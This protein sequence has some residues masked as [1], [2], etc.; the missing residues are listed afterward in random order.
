[1]TP[2]QIVGLGVRLFAIWLGLTAISDFVHALPVVFNP[3]PGYGEHSTAAALLVTG[4]VA[5]LFSTTAAL[6]WLFP[7]TVAHALVP[8][9][10][11]DN[12]LHASTLEVARVGCC[13]LGLWLLLETGP[14]LVSF[15]VRSFLVAGSGPYIETLPLQT[16]L[17]LAVTVTQVAL[18]LLFVFR[19]GAIARMVTATSATSATR[20]E[21]Q[22]EA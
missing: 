7:M 19:S 13:L 12:K 4:A 5:F 22:D 6:L 9:T 10:Y 2:Q 18:A 3:P 17:G 14:H 20:V 1:M 8:K 15:I 11:F 21:P 16:K